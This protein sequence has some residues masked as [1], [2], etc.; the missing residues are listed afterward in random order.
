LLQAAT[1]G[2]SLAAASELSV[3]LDSDTVNQYDDDF[4]ILNW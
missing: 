3:Y 4:N 1:S 2:A